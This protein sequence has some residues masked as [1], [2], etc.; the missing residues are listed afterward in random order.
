MA[1]TLGKTYRKWIFNPGQAIEVEIG[2]GS[3]RLLYDLASSMPET[4]FIGIDK[5]SDWFDLA[6][7]RARK[8]GQIQNIQYLH[9]EGLS[10]LTTNIP[11]SRIRCIHLYFPTPYPKEDRILSPKFIDEIYRVLEYGGELRVITDSRDYFY[12]LAELLEYAGWQYLNWTSLCIPLSKGQLIG[13]PCER[14]YGS[15]YVFRGIK[16]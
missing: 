1:L 12:N 4:Y 14:E 3:S 9:A 6:K 2:Y 8:E 13:T 11:S 5:N 15:R 10:F 7:R 16:S